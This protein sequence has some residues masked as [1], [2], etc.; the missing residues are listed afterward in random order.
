MTE[1]SPRRPRAPGPTNARNS[2]PGANRRVLSV[3][4]SM[5]NSIPKTK[6]EPGAGDALPVDYPRVRS[7]DRDIFRLAFVTDCMEHQCRCRDD[8]D[9]PRA[10]ACC[11]H[12]SDVLLPEKAAILRR[13]PSIASVL[14]PKWRDPENWFD[15]REPGTTDEAPFEPII[16]TRTTELDVEGLGLRF[17]RE[18]RDP[19]L[20]AAPG[21]GPPT[22]SSRPKIKPS[23]CRLYPLSLDEGRL[24]LSDDFDRYCVRECG[25][26]QSLHGDAPGSGGDSTEEPRRRARSTR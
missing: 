6:S 10:D 12:G 4:A 21:R 16:R 9:R 13:A 11:Q 2:S 14:K 20:R 18:H 23:V 19:R 8:G 3:A 1:W 15:E 5:S 17:P 26:H 22:A 24:G 7:V 25:Q